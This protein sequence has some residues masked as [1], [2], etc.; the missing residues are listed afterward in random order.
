MLTTY[1]VYFGVLAITLYLTQLFRRTIVCG[2]IT[3]HKSERVDMKSVLLIS[4]PFVLLLSLRYNIGTDYPRYSMFFDY[5]FSTKWV[6]FEPGYEFLMIITEK[7]NQGFPFLIFLTTL[8]T[9]LPVMYFIFSSECKQKEYMVIV[10]YLL[11]LGSWESL[12]RQ[13]IAF[14]FCA[15]ACQSIENRRLMRFIVFMAIAVV[16]HYMSIVVAPLY[17]LSRKSISVE[18]KTGIRV[19]KLA[20][21]VIAKLVVVVVFGIAISLFYIIYGSALGLAYSNYL[22]SDREGGTSIYL[23]L[24]SLGLLI[25]ELLNIKAVLRKYPNFEIYY[26]M[27]VLEAILYGIGML[28]PYGFRVAQ[29]FTIGHVVLAP[30]VIDIQNKNNSFIVKVYYLVLLIGQFVVLYL[31]W[32]YGGITPYRTL[33]GNLP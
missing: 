30:A 24:V 5:F 19:S 12:I 3:L 13:V 31:M 23:L 15:L 2:S 32:G 20:N 22:T 6:S 33:I 25:P 26:Y 28:I 4:T 27:V 18:L 21:R 11:M 10:L 29:Y 16:F 17:I 1:I 14:S 9:V 7:L 8:L